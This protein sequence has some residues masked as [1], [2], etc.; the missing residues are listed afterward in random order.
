[1]LDNI[2]QL[3][4]PL[5]WVGG[6]WDRSQSGPD[7]AFSRAPANPLNR[8]VAVEADHL[9]TPTAAREAVL[10]WLRELR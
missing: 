9:G 10:V 6:M 1:M 8:Y 5:L 4:A 2:S 7:Y 3:R